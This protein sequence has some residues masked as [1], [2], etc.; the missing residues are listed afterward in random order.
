MNTWDEEIVKSKELTQTMEKLYNPVKGPNLRIKVIEREENPKAQ[1]I[2][3][4]ELQKKKIPYLKEEIPVKVQETYRTK[5][6]RPE[7]KDSSSRNNQNTKHTKQRKNIK[8]CK[9]KRPNN[10]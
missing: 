9:G 5:Q 1:K 3:S 10:I 7:K 4:T 8:S 2:F 6:I